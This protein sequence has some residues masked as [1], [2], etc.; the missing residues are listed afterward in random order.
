MAELAPIA[1]FAFNR[2]RHL[3]RLLSSLEACDEFRRSDIWVFCDGPRT[4]RDEPQVAEVAGIADALAARHRCQV[5]R[6][7]TN[8]GLATSIVEGVGSLASRFGRVIVLEDDLV[9]ARGFLRYM[10]GALERYVTNPNVLQVSG[11][12]FSAT[13]YR[14]SVGSS[15]LPMVTT[16]GWATWERA[17]ALYQATP[18][19]AAAL[20][21][22]R[23]LR[24]RFDLDGAYPYHRTLARLRRNGRL[25]NSW[26]LRWYWTLFR[27]GRVSLFPHRTLVRHLGDDGTG[28]NC[29]AGYREARDDFSEENAVAG[30]PAQTVVDG[31]Y[32][33]AVRATLASDQHPLRKALRYARSAPQ[34]IRGLVAR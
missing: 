9:V 32:F 7:P 1:I 27:A 21:S 12:S 16:W 29:R 26:G 22:D 24:R 23:A 14:G 34:V 17:W 31:S 30:F 28:T 15:F 19:D 20:D 3:E 2:P 6:Q 25:G 33:N 13:G 4:A 11:H 8:R 5:V 10:N 18:I